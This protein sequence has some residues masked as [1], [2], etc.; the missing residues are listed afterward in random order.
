MTVLKLKRVDSLLQRGLQMRGDL[1]LRPG[2][3][4]AAQPNN[5]GKRRTL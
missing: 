5:E 3:H 4:L 2:H 1:E